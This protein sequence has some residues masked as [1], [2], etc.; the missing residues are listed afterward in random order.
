[1]GANS[2]PT[3]SSPSPSL[4][5]NNTTQNNN[6][7][8]RRGPRRFL[9]PRQSA[10]G[11]RRLGSSTRQD[12]GQVNNNGNKPPPQVV[13]SMLDV[14]DYAD[15]GSIKLRRPGAR[16]AAEP[17]TPNN[18]RSM[19]DVDDNTERDTDA[20]D[21][22]STDGVAAAAAP[23]PANK[24]RMGRFGRMK[25][26][27]RKPRAGSHGQDQL[28]VQDEYDPSVVD[29]LDVVDPEVATLNSITNVQNSLFIPSLGRLVN[30]RPT[31]NLSSVPRLPGAF[32]PEANE[33]SRAQTPDRLQPIE[34]NEASE[35]GTPTTEDEQTL[36]RPSM[37]RIPST[38]TDRFYAVR[39]SNTSLADWSDEDLAELN[40][41]VRHMLH[42]KRSAFKRRMKAFGQYVRKPLGFFVTLY[43]TLITLFGL[44]WVLF[45]IGWINVGGKQLYVINVIDNVLV[46][47]FAIMG[48]GLIPW[49]LVDTYHMIFI[50]R[51][52][53]LTW[54][55]RD[56]M[57][58]PELKDKNDLPSQP[59]VSNPEEQ[60]DLEAARDP[61]F[62]EGE[63]SVL[64][65]EQ[66]KKLEHHQ[67]KF[68]KSHTFYK[69][70]E[71]E[72][73]FAFP[74]R[75]LVA[76]V[77]LLDCH[78]CFQLALGL[79][80]WLIDYRTRPG[81]LT[82][83]I[84]CCSIAVNTTAGI[85]IT[86]GD[87]RTRKKDVVERMFRQELT[88]EAMRRI[89][90]K[91]EKEAKEKEKAENRLHDIQEEDGIWP[92][93]KIDFLHRNSDDNK[94]KSRKSGELSRKSLDQSRKSLDQVGKFTS[95]VGT[96]SS[97]SMDEPRV[98]GAFPKEEN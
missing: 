66:Q 12:A 5:E 69:P 92:L 89:E 11:L 55:L 34:S 98:S 86:I 70:H 76:I 40:D 17:Q 84:L 6:D 96:R 32:P 62:K 51:Y 79:C 14:D 24:E 39:P 22:A 74:L 93:P 88:E 25:I 45:L 94:G 47:L 50:A 10:I 61:H 31:Y 30:R 75:L 44:A 9:H 83:V 4:S 64:T 26:L 52:H 77:V 49:R 91:K 72:T 97:K 43:A 15:R 23:T 13:R 78:S 80:T 7:N 41:H 71:T 19:L 60:R 29:M 67:N 8:T 56:K 65:P 35:A 95:N 53:H 73:H 59:V 2:Q 46:A 38:M 42:S 57:E 28:I 54:K 33:M 85:L 1:M 16:S 58:V 18:V 48:D 37:E 87:R 63:Y 21:F 27:G 82:A 36:G 68:A 90:H 3:N 81:A 20:A